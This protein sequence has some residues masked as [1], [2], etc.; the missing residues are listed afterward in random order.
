MRFSMAL[1]LISWG[2]AC[3]GGAIRVPQDF[4]AIQ[5]A[6]D[7][8]VDGDRV[9]VAPGEYL[10]GAA[11]DFNRRHDPENPEGPARKDIAIIAE[12][13]ASCTFLRKLPIWGSVLN[14]H[15]G[16]TRASL[17]D[18]FTIAGGRGDN[19]DMWETVEEVLE[20]GFGGGISCFNSA[21]TI[22]NCVIARNDAPCGGGMWVSCEFEGP[23]VVG[24]LFV[25]NGSGTGSGVY[26]RGG[27]TVLNGCEFRGNLDSCAVACEFGSSTILEGCTIHGNTGDWFGGGIGCFGSLLAVSCLVVG[28]KAVTRWPDMPAMGGGV[29][30]GGGGFARLVNCTIADNHAMFGGGISAMDGGSI[31]CVN[32]VLW[33]S[34][35]VEGG[36]QVALMSNWSRGSSHITIDHSIVEG[37]RDNVYTHDGGTLQWLD[38]NSAPDPLFVQPGYWDDTWNT[39]QDFSDDDWVPG[40]YHLMPGSPA[41]GAGVVAGAGVV[42]LDGLRRADGAGIDLGA[43]EIDGQT[44]PA[45]IHFKRG[46]SNGDGAITVSDAVFALRFMFSGSRTPSCADALD[47]DD[48][49]VVE[50]TDVV[51]SLSYMFA[52]F[53]GNARCLAGQFTSCEPDHTWDVLTCET[54]APCR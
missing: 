41:I 32:T 45:A 43:Y 5:E 33:R 37:G 53:G 10:I 50:L 24:C 4:P 9:L 42:D 36:D 11:I 30:V 25:E 16:E 20:N 3:L 51:L 8:T 19:V 17:V 48:N 29:L 44:A 6:V 13:G 54:Y 40:D 1:L 26:L 21:P 2:S 31:A 47:V 18:G 12:G 46:D 23:R 28:N 22:R 49:G 14:F 35:A 7:A 34:S 27:F 38:G 39:P 15:H 52:P